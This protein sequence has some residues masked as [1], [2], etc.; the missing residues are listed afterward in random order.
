[1]FTSP[2][3]FQV[4]DAIERCGGFGRF[5]WFIL[6]FAGLSWMCDALEVGWS[7]YAS[8]APHNHGTARCCMRTT[9]LYG[10]AAGATAQ[11]AALAPQQSTVKPAGPLEARSHQITALFPLPTPGHALELFG[12]CGG[13]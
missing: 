11:P 1:M 13:V 3:R 8:I 6:F 5:Q 12:A 10:T 7:S 4:D 9:S 2:V